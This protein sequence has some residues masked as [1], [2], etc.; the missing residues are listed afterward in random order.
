MSSEAVQVV[1]DIIE[2]IV[3]ITAAVL[4]SL[5]TGI[6]AVFVG[7]EMLI[8]TI[9]VTEVKTVGQPFQREAEF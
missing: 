3:V 2:C 7:I 5:S 6:V 8:D 1:H 9:V 4:V